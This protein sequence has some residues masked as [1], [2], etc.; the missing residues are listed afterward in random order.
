MFINYRVVEEPY[1]ESLQATVQAL[2]PE[3]WIPLGGLSLWQGPQGGT[4]WRQ[5][6]VQ[7]ASRA[8]VVEYHLLEVPYWEDFEPTMQGWVRAGW[9][10]VGGV[11]PYT[12]PAGGRTYFQSM[13]RPLAPLPY[14]AAPF[15]RA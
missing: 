13:I 1:F 14:P 15:G 2:V 3:G 9:L 7:H 4:G 12:T 10:P 8:Q 5:T 11:F 6:M